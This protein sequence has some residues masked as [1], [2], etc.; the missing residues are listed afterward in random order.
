MK[1]FP[2]WKYATGNQSIIVHNAEEEAALKGEWFDLPEHLEAHL[3]EKARRIDDELRLK[4]EQKAEQDALDKE[5]QALRRDV[6]NDNSNVIPPAAPEDL[7]D[8]ETLRAT[9]AEMGLDVH[10]RAGAKKISDQIKA[11]I[12]AKGE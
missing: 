5:I 7:P 1:Q 10:P 3:D 4:R 11:A 8:I 6:G 9:A 2:K 12:E